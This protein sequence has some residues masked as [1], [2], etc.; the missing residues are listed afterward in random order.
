MTLALPF[1]LFS[2]IIESDRINKLQL[3]GGD[4]VRFSVYSFSFGMVCG[5]LSV[6]KYGKFVVCFLRS[7]RAALNAVEC[8]VAWLVLGFYG[9]GER[10]R[11]CVHTKSISLTAKHRK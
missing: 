7:K 4:A 2:E 11:H 10:G 5:F 9:E 6:H 8:S 3:G 1:F